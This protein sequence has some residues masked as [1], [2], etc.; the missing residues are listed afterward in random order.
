MMDASHSLSN[1]Q[2]WMLDGIR[3][4]EAVAGD[5][6]LLPSS[7]LSSEERFAIYQTA[8]QARLIECLRELFPVLRLMLEED[9]DA[10]AAEYIVHYP[11]TSYS[12][13]HLGD[14]FVAFLSETRPPR[15]DAQLDWADVM[16]ELA[17][18]EWTIDQVFDGP[19]IEHINVL[20]DELL[21]S[22]TSEQWLATRLTPAPCLRLLAFQFPINAYYQALKT[23][24]QPELPAPAANYLALTRRDF[25]V[26]R[27]PLEAAEFILLSAIVAGKTIG[28]ALEIASNH[29]SLEP[30]QIRDWFASWGRLGFFISLVPQS[31]QGGVR[32][33]NYLTD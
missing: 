11:P 7:Q 8:Y 28:E 32:E 29:T 12:L 19:G 31:K 20:K 13:N 24:E 2:R 21:R 15:K 4:R 22:L 25:L 16:I 9:F 26:R 18:M 33:D 27:I 10:F 5:G 23:N 6:I 1:L 14:R 17:Q 3:E 30:A